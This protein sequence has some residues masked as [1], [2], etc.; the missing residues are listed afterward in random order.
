MWCAGPLTI[1]TVLLQG[2]LRSHLS[3]G[4]AYLSELAGLTCLLAGLTCLLAGLTCLLAERRRRARV[5]VALA[6]HIPDHLV[7]DGARRGAAA[8]LA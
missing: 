3:A 4:R 8:R 7:K 6:H 5:L 2:S 1:L